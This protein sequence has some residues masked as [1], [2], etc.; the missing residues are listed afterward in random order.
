M[1]WLVKIWQVSSCGKF[2]Q[3]L[4][5]CLL[6]QLKLTDL[7]VNLWLF[8]LSFSSVFNCLDVQNE[9]QL[10]S[11]VF[12]YSWLVCLLGFWLRNTSLVK[13]GN[14]ISD[15]IVFVFHL[16]WG[17]SRLQSLT[18]YWPYLIPFR[19]ASRMVSLINYCIRCLFFLSQ[20]RSQG[21]LLPALRGDRERDPGKRLSRVSQNLGNYKQTI[22]GRG[23]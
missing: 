5:S 9:I 19:A 6:W 21:S 20:P 7:C 13:V 17:V 2:I 14:P 12:C 23:R 15:G 16:G 18:R 4:E 8:K 10:L 1:L 22:W 11:R 3:H